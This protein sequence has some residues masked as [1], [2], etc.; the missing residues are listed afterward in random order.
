M[1][2]QHC[3]SKVEYEAV[4]AYGWSSILLKGK[5]TEI[6]LDK[7]FGLIKRIK[8]ES[9]GEKDETIEITME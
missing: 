9:N 3:S 4:S 1:K 6:E 8:F 2:M 7:E 5:K